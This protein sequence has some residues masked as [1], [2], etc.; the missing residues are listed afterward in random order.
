MQTQARPAAFK[1]GLTAGMKGGVSEAHEFIEDRLGVFSI[2]PDAVITDRH[3]QET[4]ELATFD[5]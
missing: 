4:R 2:D 5:H 1:F 3:L